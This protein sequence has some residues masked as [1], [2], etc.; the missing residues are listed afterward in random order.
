MPWLLN[1]EREKRNKQR[2][3]RSG[4]IGTILLGI[5]GV[6]GGVFQDFTS[7]IL[8][9]ILVPLES[10][11]ARI[12]Q[13]HIPQEEELPEQ[14]NEIPIRPS[15][16]ELLPEEDLSTPQAAVE[17]SQQ[18][19]DGIETSDL[20]RTLVIPSEQ[21]TAAIGVGTLYDVDGIIE[22]RDSPKGEIIIRLDS[23]TQ[24]DILKSNRQHSLV[25][26]SSGIVGYVSNSRLK[27]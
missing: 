16:S 26:T 6:F 18:S 20:N 15:N 8:E 19:F 1:M 25:R 23:G 27:H 5:L 13:T 21:S 22:L 11:W 4:I 17:E 9:P 2:R 10:K 3:N 24:V 14:D 12:I 7:A